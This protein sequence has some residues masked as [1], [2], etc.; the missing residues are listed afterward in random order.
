MKILVL[1]LIFIVI[2]VV[3]S[4]VFLFLISES[5]KNLQL[6][7]SSGEVMMETFADNIILMIAVK[8]K[9][10]DSANYNTSY[11]EAIQP[12]IDSYIKKNM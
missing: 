9:M 8:E 12:I 3:F 11:K 10:L 2:A 7:L 1:F 6:I 4:G 5:T